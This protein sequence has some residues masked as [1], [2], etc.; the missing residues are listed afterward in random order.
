MILQQRNGKN[1]RTLFQV[2]VKKVTEEGRQNEHIDDSEKKDQRDPE[3]EGLDAT[4]NSDSGVD[5]EGN[6]S[7]DDGT[8]LSPFE[9]GT[10]NGSPT[11]NELENIIRTGSVPIPKQFPRD[12][13][14]QLFPLSV[15]LCNHENGGKNKRKW[16]VFS[17]S[18]E[19]LYCLPC[20]L[21]SPLIKKPTQS[22]LATASGWDKN[23][24]WKKLWGRVPRH[25][26][27]SSHR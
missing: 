16:L 23:A 25:E 20:R 26:K 27:S 17:A 5:T 4:G 12:V 8:K 9:I 11:R 24:K 14:G 19:A 22:T 13:D 10:L 15:L 3:V 7:I 6:F 18:K 1:S 2:G 21:F